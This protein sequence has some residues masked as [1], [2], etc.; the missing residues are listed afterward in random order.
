MLRFTLFGI[1]VEIQP[2]FW[3]TAGLLGGGLR[4]DTR[5]GLIGTVLFMLAA[6]VSILVHEFGHALTGRKYGGGRPRITLWAMG[7]LAQ[8]DGARLDRGGLLR[9]TAAG[10][11]AGFAFAA[12]I[13]AGLYLTFPAEDA[14]NLLRFSLLGSFQSMPSPRLRELFTENYQLVMLLRHFLWINFWWGM[15]NLLPVMPLDGGRIAELFVI[16]R[17]RLFL[18][19]GV[20]ASAMAAYGWFGMGSLYVALLFGYLAW[21]NFQSMKNFG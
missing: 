14:A 21:T 1:P 9:M 7:G 11:G 3:L 13:I 17:S 12:V 20:T 18:I 6:F 8:C 15:V 10:P 2:W 5:E 16:P 19:G 4:A